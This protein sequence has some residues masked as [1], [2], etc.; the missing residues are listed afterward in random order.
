M[1][2]FP[3]LLT[4]LL[5]LTVA[6][7]VAD[8]AA[9]DP[10]T[11]ALV[12]Q[13][14]GFYD[15]YL[16]ADYAAPEAREKRWPVCVLLHDRGSSEA[17]FRGLTTE[18]G[19]RGVIYLAPRAPH[20]ATAGFRGARGP[21]WSAWPTFPRAW[22]DWSSDRFPRAEIESMKIARMYTD[23]IAKC[24]ADVRERYRVDDRRVVV[25]GHG[26]GG[27]YA[28]LLAVH[29]PELV[30]AYF[31]YAGYYHTTTEDDIAALT[32]K[33]H[34][35]HPVLVHCEGD[36]A[37]EARETRDLDRYLTE[38]KVK[39]DCRIFPGGSHAF[40]SAVT[41]AAQEFVAS[42]CRGEELP[43]LAG[44]LVVT[45]VADGSPA[46]KA[47]LKAG[48]VLT[49]YNAVPLKNRDDLVGAASSVVAGQREV[50]ITWRRGK[51][52]QQAK[53]PAGPLGLG[54]AD[55]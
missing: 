24:V 52:E 55:R 7:A 32:L 2:R 28:H 37:A 31:A 12:Q 15:V 11:H 22:G 30:R 21:G 46:A 13:K 9:P 33:K 43:P 40:T 35:I 41:R 27:A 16:P 8:E 29:R 45:E 25:L 4:V 20:S 39:H 10:A 36:P 5:A 48:D 1:T 34:D 26:E 53:V 17:E 38:R 14:V 51:E 50:V 19:R 47:G 18:L 23:W 54:L 6:P 3:I 49:S 42:W 44:E